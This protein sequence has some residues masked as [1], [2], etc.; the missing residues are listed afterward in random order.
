[1]EGKNNGLFFG[2]FEHFLSKTT[3]HFS[4]GLLLC[5]P[6]FRFRPLRASFHQPCRP[7]HRFL[8]CWW[9]RSLAVFSGEDAM[10]QQ[11]SRWFSPSTIFSKISPSR[12][13]GKWWKNWLAQIFLKG[14]NQLGQLGIWPYERDC[15]LNGTPDS[16]NPPW[17]KPPIYP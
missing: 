11:R 4:F 1:M 17:P 10:N 7:A 8:P 6:I 2:Q 5:L 15:L 3:G 9:W 12:N 14:L 16:V 13:W